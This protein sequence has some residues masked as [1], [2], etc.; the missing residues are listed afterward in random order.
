M[1]MF[2]LCTVCAY[3]QLIVFACTWLHLITPLKMKSRSNATGLKPEGHIYEVASSK[4]C[5]NNTCFS[6]IRIPY[7]VPGGINNGHWHPVPL[8]VYYI[9]IYL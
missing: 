1:V 2:V 3:L 7:V 8:S 5:N 9:F 4:S 6:E